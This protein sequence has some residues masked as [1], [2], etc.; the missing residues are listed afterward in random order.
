MNRICSTMIWSIGNK[1]II[2]PQHAI[3]SPLSEI[4]LSIQFD[5]DRKGERLQGMHKKKH[6]LGH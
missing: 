2:S 5:T 1:S 6:L 4:T 3:I